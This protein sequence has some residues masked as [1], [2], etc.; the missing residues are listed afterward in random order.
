[1][2]RHQAYM[3]LMREL[4]RRLH[5]TCC[6]FTNMSSH[7]SNSMR[8]I[9]LL[10][11]SMLVVSLSIGERRARCGCVCRRCACCRSSREDEQFRMPADRLKFQFKLDTDLFALVKGKLTAVSVAM[12]PSGDRFAVMSADRFVRVFVFDTGKVRAS[13]ISVSGY[14]R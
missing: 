6:S 7:T 13:V 3:C 4:M 8:C 12:A 2:E 11:L 9:Q 14:V 10:R 1:M 5:C